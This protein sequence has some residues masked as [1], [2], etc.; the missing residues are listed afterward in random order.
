MTARGAIVVPDATSDKRRGGPARQRLLPDPSPQ[1]NRVRVDVWVPYDEA[2]ARMAAA[3]TTGGHL[4]NDA[5]APAAA[6]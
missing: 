4:V 2:E 3:L 1:H 6:R 5:D